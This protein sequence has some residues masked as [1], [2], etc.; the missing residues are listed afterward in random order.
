MDATLWNTASDRF[1]A[2]EH[3]VLA[4]EGRRPVSDDRLGEPFDFSD[5]LGGQ[6]EPGPNRTTC[7]EYV[8]DTAGW[9]LGCVGGIAASVASLSFCAALRLVG[10]GVLLFECLVRNVVAIAFDLLERRWYHIVRGH[11]H[12]S[13]RPA[14]EMKPDTHAGRANALGSSYSAVNVTGIP[15]IKAYKPRS[16][17]AKCR[18]KL[19]RMLAGDAGLQGSVHDLNLAKYFAMLSCAVYERDAM[20]DEVFRNSGF[21]EG[22]T[23]RIAEP[24]CGCTVGFKGVRDCLVVAVVFK[25]A[26][27]FELK[28][29]M[30]D[31]SAG[32]VADYAFLAEYGFGVGGRGAPG[33]V[34]EG[35]YDAFVSKPARGEGRPPLKKILSVLSRVA[36]AEPN[37]GKRL[38]LWVAGHS[39][40]AALATMFTAFVVSPEIAKERYAPCVE[41][42]EDWSAVLELLCESLAGVYTYG[43]P[44][45]GD[46]VFAD[47]VNGALS[48][49]SVPFRRFRNG[50]DI[51]GVVPMG[52][53]LLAEIHRLWSSVV[54]TSN[55]LPTQDFCSATDWGEVGKEFRLGYVG[56]FPHRSVEYPSSTVSGETGGPGAVGGVGALVH[57]ALFWRVERLVE[58]VLLSASNCFLSLCWELP[59]AVFNLIWQRLTAP[60][61]E[62][63]GG[64]ESKLRSALLTLLSLLFMPSF[65]YDH[66]PSQYAKNIDRATRDM[67]R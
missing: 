6:A 30:A 31:C 51:V 45:V 33:R 36:N 53:G 50:N 41:G 19:D 49:L 67:W 48:R 11:P 44:R 24:G 57:G 43:N 14:Y 62:F 7:G 52:T 3:G 39:L 66:L 28:E 13:S 27:P 47:N 20:H 22:Q 56:L 54:S 2:G 61:H 21:D 10:A 59:L 46:R 16:F 42:E 64:E 58:D 12:P 55:A 17:G 34:H 37:R 25:G 9:L 8:T 18:D 60:L 32:K 1:A 63:I 40:G 65:V 35:F 15:Y 4:C 38:R 29:W 26:S 5:V 23:V